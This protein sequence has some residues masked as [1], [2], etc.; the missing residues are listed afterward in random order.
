MDWRL[1]N[2]CVYC[3]DYAD[4]RD[5]VPSK[6]FLDEPY[7][8]NLSVVPCCLKC[9]N[10]FSKDEEYVSCLIDCINEG[11]ENPLKVSR[12]KTRK[13]LEHS[14]KL[15]NEIKTEIIP[16]E[17]GIKYTYNKH[18]FE[19]VMFKLAYGHLAYENSTLSFD[20]KYQV[21][22]DLLKQSDA[23]TLS[24]FEEPYYSDL[25]PEV[26]SRSLSKI[27]GFLVQEGY[28]GFKC[29]SNWQGI[30]N[31]RYRYCVAP[32]SNRIKIVIAECLAIEVIIFD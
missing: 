18:R 29:C 11:V 14:A 31:G 3:G 21:R 6:C 27:G 7:P 26:G 22:I 5:H 20:S 24:V 16:L 32:E 4:T 17:N 28:N 9:N 15:A 13:T 30:Q 12:L 1:T 19:Q 2:T 25:L 8:D 10:M 23:H